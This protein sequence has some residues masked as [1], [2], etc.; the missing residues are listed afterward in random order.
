MKTYQ[1]VNSRGVECEPQQDLDWGGLVTSREP[2]SKCDFSLA[3]EGGP[4]SL[5]FN[6]SSSPAR[7]MLRLHAGPRIRCATGS[8]SRVSVCMSTWLV[9]GSPLARRFCRPHK[10]TSRGWDEAEQFIRRTLAIIWFK[11]VFFFCFLHLGTRHQTS[12]AQEEA[13]TCSA[14]PG[15]RGRG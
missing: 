9:G 15:L 8:R 5:C 10:Q 4:A 11:S 3:D 12:T 1:K 14:G 6:L 2:I 13:A 7:L